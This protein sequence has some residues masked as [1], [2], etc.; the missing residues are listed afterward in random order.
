MATVD[1]EGNVTA[2]KGGKAI[3]TATSEENPNISASCVVTVVEP[4]AGVILSET[5]YK[6][7]NIGESV[8]LTATVLPEEAGN[9]NV[10]WTSSDTSICVVSKGLVVATGFGTAV[11]FVTTE[12]GEY[13]AFCTITVEK[14]TSVADIET[15]L[16]NQHPIYN[17]MGNKVERTTKGHLYIKKGK[18]FLIK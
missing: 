6:M 4:V 12:E 11:I 3:I 10:K 7:K 16:P 8:Q 1:E 18:K 14:E 13:M 5:T 15:D 9:K 2:V 17:L